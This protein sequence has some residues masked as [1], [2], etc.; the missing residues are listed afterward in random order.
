MMFP[1][2]GDYSGTSDRVDFYFFIT[3]FS[4]RRYLSKAYLYWKA[5]KLS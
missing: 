2:F 4:A 5:V 1:A 3:V